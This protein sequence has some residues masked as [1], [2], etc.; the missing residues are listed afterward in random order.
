MWRDGTQGVAST[1]KYVWLPAVVIVGREI[2]FGH[3][4]P[5][6]RTV[7]RPRTTRENAS[8]TARAVRSDP[9]RYV[10]TAPTAGNRTMYVRIGN[11]I[12]IYRPPNHGNEARVYALIIP[13][14]GTG[15]KPTR[16]TRATRTTYETR[17]QGRG[18]E[19][20]ASVEG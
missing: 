6:R 9:V 2:T 12:C 14:N 5:M 4:N 16:K 3:R 17:S 20:G 10:K 7:D 15:K 1:A 11:S 8:A 19:E 13:R 18:H